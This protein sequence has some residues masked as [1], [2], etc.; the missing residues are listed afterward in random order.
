MLAVE[1][2]PEGTAYSRWLRRRRR[3]DLGAV[4]VGERSWVTLPAF[5]FLAWRLRTTR[6]YVLVGWL[7][8]L[9]ALVPMNGFVQ[10]GGQAYADRYTYFPSLDRTQL[11]H[12][13]APC[14]G[15]H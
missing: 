11:V 10:V 7:W 14:L 4:E 15:A 8:F 12:S 6:P 5:T 9:G 1:Q 13:S 3:D 2:V